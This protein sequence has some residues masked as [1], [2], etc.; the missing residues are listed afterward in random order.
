MKLISL[1]T[2]FL[3]TCGA[4]IVQAPNSSI[5]TYS[6]IYATPDSS[7]VVT[8]VGD[9]KFITAMHCAAKWNHTFL[10]CPASDVA[11]VELNLDL[12]NH[13]V[14]YVGQYRPGTLICAVT[15]WGGRTC[16]TAPNLSPDGDLYIGWLE[17]HPGDSGSPIYNQQGDIVAILHSTQPDRGWRGIASPLPLNK[18]EPCVVLQG[19]L[20]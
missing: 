7:C 2:P 13:N 11:I 20:Q 15:R 14:R 19:P 4:S 17:A 1:L 5:P 10:G 9:G 3:V 12:P 8:D 18:R 16:G 6:D